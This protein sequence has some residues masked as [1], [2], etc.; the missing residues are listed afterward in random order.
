MFR[1]GQPTLHRGGVVRARGVQRRLNGRDGPRLTQARLQQRGGWAGG[2]TTDG[3][4]FTEARLHPE[5]GDFKLDDK[6]L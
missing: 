5:R 4:R 3:S 6:G 2:G 1:L